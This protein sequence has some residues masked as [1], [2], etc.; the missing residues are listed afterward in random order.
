MEEWFVVSVNVDVNA[1][2]LPTPPLPPVGPSCN[3]KMCQMRE[4]LPHAKTV[5]QK[6]IGEM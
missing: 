5:G 3:D 4:E 6:G 1:G 2:E